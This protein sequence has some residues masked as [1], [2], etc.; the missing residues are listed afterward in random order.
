MPCKDISFEEVWTSKNNH[1]LT[2]TII[3]SDWSIMWHR[4][5][6]SRIDMILIESTNIRVR[7]CQISENFFHDTQ[8]RIP[9]SLKHNFW[10]SQ[11]A[12]YCEKHQICDLLYSIIQLKFKC[13][14][15]MCYDCQCL[16]FL[17]IS[18][19]RIKSIPVNKWEGCK[20][21]QSYYMITNVSRW[22]L[23]KSHT[24]SKAVSVQT[25]LEAS[26]VMFEW[27]WDS[28]LNVVKKTFWDLAIP[29]TYVCKLY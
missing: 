10:C 26:K 8:S 11:T 25:N 21:L 15:K 19:F 12:L 1:V 18:F 23:F 2:F 7:Y 20:T 17:F 9:C 3:E 22:W 6:F 27:T 5:L 29:H 24:P 16:I 28:T 14:E 13:C 4:R